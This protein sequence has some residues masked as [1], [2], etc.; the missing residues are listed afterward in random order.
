MALVGAIKKHSIIMVLVAISV[1]QLLV[2]NFIC[3]PSLKDSPHEPHI[4]KLCSEHRRQALHGAASYAVN[5][6]GKHCM[7]QQALQ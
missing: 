2:V 7:V 6:A 1:C 5:I 4:V 3:S